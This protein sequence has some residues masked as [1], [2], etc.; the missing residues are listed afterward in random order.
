MRR[1]PGARA[2]G[3]TGDR[4]AAV[5][6]PT[7]S[8]L[9]DRL[10]VRDAHGERLL[11]DHLSFLAPA[12]QIT[13]L[14]S[15]SWST[16]HYCALALLG[17]LCPS[18]G[19]ILLKGFDVGAVPLS[20]MRRALAWVPQDS[21]W[22]GT[23]AERL[24]IP[25]LRYGTLEV[26]TVARKAMIHDA[27]LDLVQGY[28]TPVAHPSLTRGLRQRIEIAAAL[29]ARKPVLLIDEL[30]EH[31]S[32]EERAAWL[33]ALDGLRGHHT[34]IL[35]GR[36]VASTRASDSIV[37]LEAGKVFEEGPHEALLAWGD[38][39][40]QLVRTSGGLL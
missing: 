20:Q 18:S 40:A 30:G 22:Q 38:R 14:V 13:S 33:A 31:L 19:A 21:S 1:I 6:C 7:P 17:R 26:E 3:S 35:L 12:G 39:Y 2:I 23:I 28:D 34:V 36:S 8:V 10:C 27:V 15:A 11:L 4:I 5:P 32:E 24:Q 16:L 29:L 9:F 37:V 25:D